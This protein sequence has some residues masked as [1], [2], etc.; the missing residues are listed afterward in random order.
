MPMFSGS[1]SRAISSITSMA[2]PEL[3]PCAA[4]PV[5]V[6]ELN[7]LNRLITPGPVV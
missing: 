3:C 6:A 1:F 2:C 7:M 4:S 5:M